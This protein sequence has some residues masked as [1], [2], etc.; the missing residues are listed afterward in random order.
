MVG[1][2][3]ARPG[4]I[5][6]ENKEQT[7][8]AFAGVVFFH[9]QRQKQ[10]AGRARGL[11]SKGGK[12]DG[13]RDRNHAAGRATAG[14]NAEPLSAEPDTQEDVSGAHFKGGGGSQEGGQKPS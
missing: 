2:A 11:R 4:T 1:G 7:A 10:G 3:A 13:G 6:A 12:R 9:T 14:R 5:S 8:P